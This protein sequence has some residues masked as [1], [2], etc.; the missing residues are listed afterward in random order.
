MENSIIPE[1]NGKKRIYKISGDKEF[2]NDEI[3]KLKEEFYSGPGGYW[4]EISRYEDGSGAEV[5]VI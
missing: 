2:I 3:K 5:T 4:V 1:R